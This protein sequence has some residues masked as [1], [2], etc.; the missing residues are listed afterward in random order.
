[1]RSAWPPIVTWLL[2]GSVTPNV[3]PVTT[4]LGSRMMLRLIGSWFCG[5]TT[6]PCS[7]KRRFESW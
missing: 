6:P 2:P 1:M 3:P 5:F 4:S 7:P